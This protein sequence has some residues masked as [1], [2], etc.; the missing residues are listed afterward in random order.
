MFWHKSKMAQE[1]FYTDLQYLNPHMSK[2]GTIYE[3]WKCNNV[4]GWRMIPLSLSDFIWKL[5]LVDLLLTQSLL[6]DQLSLCLPTVY[7]VLLHIQHAATVSTFTTE[8]TEKYL[9]LD[10]FYKTSLYTD[11]VPVCRFGY[12]YETNW[13]VKRKFMVYFPDEFSI[14][15]VIVTQWVML[16]LHSPASV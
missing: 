3:V 8:N 15:V 16:T 9:V 6:H 10:C 11:F 12:K 4:T 1:G 2:S 13:P 14:N 5:D 7:C